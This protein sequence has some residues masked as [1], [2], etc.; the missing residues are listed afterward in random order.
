MTYEYA[1]MHQIRKFWFPRTACNDIHDFM[2]S[3]SKPLC[4]GLF[5]FLLSHTSGSIL[6]TLNHSCNTEVKVAVLQYNTQFWQ[7]T[8][9]T[10]KHP[11]QLWLSDWEWWCYMQYIYIILTSFID[12]LKVTK[13]PSNKSGMTYLLWSYSSRWHEIAWFLIP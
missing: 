2:R 11:V 3:D 1:S 8:L 4:Y 5:L 10:H 6:A 7:L 12:L 9:S 13:L